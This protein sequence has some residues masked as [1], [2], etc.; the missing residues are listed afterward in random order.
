MRPATRSIDSV[1]RIACAIPPPV[2]PYGF[3]IFVKKSRFR[4]LKPFR[5][6]WPT[7]AQ[8]IETESTVRM[9]IKTAL[10]APP[11]RLRMNRR[12]SRSCIAGTLP[13]DDPPDEDPGTDVEEGGDK[14]KHESQL[15]NGAEIDRRIGFRELVGDRAGNRV[16]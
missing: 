12:L 16:A 13:P 10:A 4:D 11:R 7:M 3:G 14:E 15:D 1:P 8:R 5:K 6:I 2:S 9:V